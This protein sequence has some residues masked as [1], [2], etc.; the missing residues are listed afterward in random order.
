[1]EIWLNFTFIFFPSF[2][3]RIVELMFLL[4]NFIM[5]FYH[6]LLNRSAPMEM[7]FYMELAHNIQLFSPWIFLP[8]V[9]CSIHKLTPFMDAP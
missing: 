9:V 4:D 1:M 3:R 6:S 2:L 8:A 5:Q 7:L